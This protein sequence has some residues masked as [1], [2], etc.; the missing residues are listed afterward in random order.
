MNSE[1]IEL[2]RQLVKTTRPKE[3]TQVVLSGERTDFI[4]RFNP[5]LKLDDS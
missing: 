5:P 4:T 3:E 1:T 2:I